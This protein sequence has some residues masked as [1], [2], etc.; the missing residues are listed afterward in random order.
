M[1]NN[2]DISP[3]LDKGLKAFGFDQEI[4]DCLYFCEHFS[5]VENI[6]LKLHLEKAVAFQAT[7]VFFRMELSKY[8]PQV[9]LYD[10]TG[11]KLKENILTG[12]HKKVWSSGKVPIVCIFYDTE[13]RI[14]DCSQPIKKNGKPAYLETIS[15]VQK[16]HHLYNKEFAF[17]LKTGIFWE[18]EDNKAKFKF[19]ENSAYDILILWVREIIKEISITNT[20]LN[21]EQDI[22]VI[23]KVIIQSIMIKYFEERKDEFGNSPFHQKYFQKY[24]GSNE[25]IDV[26]SSGKLVNLL[27]DLESD[28]NGN[29]FKS[30]VR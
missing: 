6:E 9:Y 14:L 11:Q 3:T 17:K 26:V 2:I 12:I 18:E 23:K 5:S 28:L 19:Q 27:E 21:K 15:L 29:L 16:A 24:N 7:A 4:E 10:F 22:R 25:F 8:K 30:I 13:V 20:T 1:F